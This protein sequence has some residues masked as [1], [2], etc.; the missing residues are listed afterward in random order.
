MNRLLLLVLAA[1]ITLGTAPTQAG[2]LELL[3]HIGGHESPGVCNGRY[4]YR[5]QGQELVTFDA[6]DPAHPREI[7]RLMLPMVPEQLK[8]VEKKLFIRAM[9]F[10]Y[11]TAEERDDLAVCDISNPAAPCNPR[12]IPGTSGIINRPFEIASNC[13]IF[14]SI[15]CRLELLDISNLNAPQQ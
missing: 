14:S 2:R 9:R 1:L 3:S 7:H 13:I 4:V 11:S 6:T 12:V 5:S 8:L 15:Y 10:S